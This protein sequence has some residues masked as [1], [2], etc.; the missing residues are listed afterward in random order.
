MQSYKNEISRLVKLATPI[1]L[2]SSAQTGIGFVDTVMAGGVSATDLAGV[3]IATSIWLPSILFG[4][5]ILMALVPIVAQLNG[6][7][8]KSE[9]ANEV[10]QAIVMG[11]FVSV[12]IIAVFFQVQWILGLMN[13]EPKLEDIS[14]GYMM[15]VMPAVPAVMLFQAFRSY[16]DGMS[17]TKPAMVISFIGLF[18]NIPLNW[19]FVY[20]EFGAPALGGVGCGVATTIVQWLMLSAMVFYVVTS[21]KLKPIGTFSKLHLPKFS[22]QI[23]LLKLGFPIAASIFFEV[24]LFSVVAII[25]A[26]LGSVVVAAHQIALNFSSLIF[27]LPLSLGAA[28]SI[29]VGHQLGESNADGAKISAIVG[30][31]VGCSLAVVTGVLTV[32]FREA[33]TQL[34]TDSAPVITFAMHLLLFSAAYQMADTIQV[35]AAGALRGYKD[36]RAIFYCTFIS[37]WLLGLPTGYAFGM[38]DIFGEPMGAAGFWVGFIVGLSAAALLLS[39]RLKWIHNQDESVR[40]SYMAK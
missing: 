32:V 5:G 10:Q 34:Y 28:V 13:V 31:I 14:S 3:A 25:I 2:A 23:R 20:G 9:I 12:P 17:L 6:A 36:M 1:L 24:T 22:A 37:Y 4:I 26:P 38:T 21:R 19:M 16:T 29:R 33:I 7:N 11:L 40:Y 15:M 35:I 8:R 18:A 27:M 39:L 30:F